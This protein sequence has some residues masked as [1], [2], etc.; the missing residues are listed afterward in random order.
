[1]AH[2]V[3]RGQVTGSRRFGLLPAEATS[4]VG[5]TIELAGITAL[6]GSARMV[7]VTGPAGV[8]KTRIS[9]CAASMMAGQYPDGMFFADLAGISDPAQVTD[10]ILF[11]HEIFGHDRFMLQLTVGSMPHDKV[12]HAIELY[13][14]EVAPAVRAELARRGY[15]PAEAPT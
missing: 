1:M 9:V 13:G 15:S 2:V 10:K 11:Q 14:T 4:F 12:M 7:S 8:G 5:R 6:L 3:S